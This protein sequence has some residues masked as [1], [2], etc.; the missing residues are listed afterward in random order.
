[1]ETQLDLISTHEHIKD[2]AHCGLRY[3]WRRSPSSSL[4]MT[5][6]GSL[7]EKADLGFTI[8]TLLRAERVPRPTWYPPRNCN[9]PVRFRTGNL[10]RWLYVLCSERSCTARVPAQSGWCTTGGHI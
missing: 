4:K 9:V 10:L 5:Y 8:E 6:C 2:C 7:C 1:M 3:D